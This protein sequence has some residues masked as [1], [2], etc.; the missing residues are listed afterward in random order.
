[1]DRRDDPRAH[2]YIVDHLSPGGELTR[3]FEV[4]NS[5][6]AP[7]ELDLYA[8][9]AAISDGSF[10]PAG[11]RTENDVTRWTTVTPSSVVVQP[12]ATE[13]ARVTISVPEDA[14]AGERYGVVLA[15]APPV[16]A[17]DTAAVAP[18]VGI[19]IYL[20][21]GEGGEPASDFVVDSLQAGREES[22]RPV[23]LARVENTGGRALDMRGELVL[24]EG[25]GGLSAGPFGV[26]LGTTIA[27][28]QSSPVRIALDPEIPDG[29]WL[30]RLKLQSGELERQVEAEITFP[31]QS[32]ALEDPVEA[33][34][35]ERQR[36][37]LIPLAA[38]ALTLVVAGLIWYVLGRRR[39]AQL[40]KKGVQ[41]VARG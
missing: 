8:G 10:V 11:A 32:G 24:A 38:G 21:V 36:K 34:P 5:T 35:V 3:S 15:E 19:R 17:S 12:G 30:A 2:S 16:Q 14:S 6:D 28:G 18:R 26:E 40:A 37:V 41:R 13:P 7:V 27:P 1:M 20:S 23:V 4:S 29:P 22:G 31:E 9:A 33:S 25:P 39:A